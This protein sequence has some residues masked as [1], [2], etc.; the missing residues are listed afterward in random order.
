MCCHITS[1]AGSSFQNW[2]ALRLN[3]KAQGIPSIIH[4]NRLLLLCITCLC[5]KESGFNAEM[6]ARLHDDCLEYPVF[7]GMQSFRLRSVCYVYRALWTASSYKSK[8]LLGNPFLCQSN[9]AS[10]AGSPRLRS[11]RPPLVWS[12]TSVL[13]KLGL[14]SRR[15]SA[16]LCCP[17]LFGTGSLESEADRSAAS[18]NPERILQIATGFCP[19]MK[20][21]FRR[22]SPSDG[23]DVIRLVRRAVS[24]ITEAGETC[25]SL[26]HKRHLL[27]TTR[28]VPC[29]SLQTLTDDMRRSEAA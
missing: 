7:F 25:H 15:L 1:K 23:R 10:I 11:F 9:L 13:V 3:R 20:A 17:F 22:L 6:E 14:V 8:P 2:A 12:S 19:W 4:H 18:S 5:A 24:R 26:T 28:L 16:W 29:R 21:R 27:N